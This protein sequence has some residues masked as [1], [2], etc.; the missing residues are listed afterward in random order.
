MTI[1]VGL[2]KGIEKIVPIQVLWEANGNMLCFPGGYWE[3][4]YKRYKGEE[5]KVGRKGFSSLMQIW[6]LWKE[7]GRKDKLD[8]KNLSLWYNFKKV[9]VA[10]KINRKLWDKEGP[11]VSSKLKINS[12]NNFA[13]FS[14]WL[15]LMEISKLQLKCG[16]GFLGDCS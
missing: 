12:H 6:R 1:F 15:M 3:K 11:A 13:I 10:H 2:P 7:M 4:I 14:Y 9:L 16:G 8:R 5:T